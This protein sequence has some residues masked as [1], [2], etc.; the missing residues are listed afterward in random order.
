MAFEKHGISKLFTF[1]IIYLL[2]NGKE[3]LL[4]LIKYVLFIHIIKDQSQETNLI[5]L[6][7]IEL[8]ARRD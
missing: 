8:F 1:K 5:D 6:K 7:N 2:L 3:N 4:F